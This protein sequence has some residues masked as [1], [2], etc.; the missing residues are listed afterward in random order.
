[1]ITHVKLVY[2][3]FNNNK[4]KYRSRLVARRVLR[5]SYIIE[6]QIKAMFSFFNPGMQG[7]TWV[8]VEVG[9]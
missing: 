7:K 5:K 4:V 6:Y 9:K 3:R 2:S 1:M 8:G